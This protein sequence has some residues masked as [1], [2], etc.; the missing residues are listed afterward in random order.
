MRYARG[1]YFSSFLPFPGLWDNML[2]VWGKRARM[3]PGRSTARSS[4]YPCLSPSAVPGRDLARSGAVWVRSVISAL[5]EQD[6]VPVHKG[7]IPYPISHLSEIPSKLKLFTQQLQF[8]F[9]LLDK[10]NM[11]QSVNEF[12]IDTYLITVAADRRSKSCIRKSAF[13]ADC[14]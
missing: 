6:P 11:S 2:A 1:S 14:V 7:E 5:A 9:S 13:P 12:R 8:Q 3:R 4:S 10:E